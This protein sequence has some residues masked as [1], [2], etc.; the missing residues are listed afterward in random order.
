M[1]KKKRML[2]ESCCSPAI[3]KQRERQYQ[4]E[5]GVRTLQRAGEIVKDKKLLKDIKQ[6]AQ[7]QISDLNK[8]AK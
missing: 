2:V 1:A 4:I 8:V 3:D 6:F 7:Q 5:D